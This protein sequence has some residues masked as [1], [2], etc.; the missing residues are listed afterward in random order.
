MA[1]STSRSDDGSFLRT[2]A[3]VLHK[4]YADERYFFGGK[5]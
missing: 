2:T 1:A 3:F 4:F 5:P